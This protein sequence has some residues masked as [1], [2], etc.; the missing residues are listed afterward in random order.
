MITDINSENRLVQ[1]IFAE[2]LE[3]A[4]GWGSVYAHN[5]ET[6]G[7]NGTLGCVSARTASSF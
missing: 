3:H 2:H 5:T 1:Q 4:L 6:F 7:P